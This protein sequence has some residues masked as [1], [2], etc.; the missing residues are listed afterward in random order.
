VRVQALHLV[1]PR[2]RSAG[3][4]TIVVVAFVL[5]L[6]RPASAHTPTASGSTSC[7]DANHL[8]SWT[9]HNSDRDFGTMTIASATATIGGTTYAVTGYEADV[10]P[11]STTHAT[12]TVPGDVT[13]TID[14]TLQVH[15]PDGFKNHAS[16]S[17]ELQAPCH[18]TT[19]TTPSTTS[20]STTTPSS[21]PNSSTTGGP[22]VTGGTAPSSGGGGAGGEQAGGQGGVEGGVAGIEAGSGGTLPKTGASSTNW[23]LVG[24]TAVAFG[25]ALLAVSKRGVRGLFA[26]R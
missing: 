14:L 19:T 8:V 16:A 15:W 18:E 26:R 24:F 25:G 20:P 1:R 22:P 9:I 23:A 6:A 13:G 7:P 3:I 5:A 12:T 21:Q 10:P 11:L 2:A 4:V 17:V